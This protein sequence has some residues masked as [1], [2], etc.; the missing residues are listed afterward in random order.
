MTLPGTL[1][2]YFLCG[3]SI[4]VIMKEIPNGET[5]TTS[6][7]LCHLSSYIFSFFFSFFSFLPPAFSSILLAIFIATIYPFLAS[8]MWVFHYPSSLSYELE[9]EQVVWGR[10]ALKGLTYLVTDRGT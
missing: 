2:A 7:I 8:K 4:S 1:G 6:T 3:G 5:V 9:V 10:L